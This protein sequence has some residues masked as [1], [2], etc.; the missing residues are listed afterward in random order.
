MNSENKLA[1]PHTDNQTSQ[2]DALNGTNTSL[3]ADSNRGASNDDSVSSK[4][5]D[6]A[7]EN[8]AKALSMCVLTFGGILMLTYFARIEFLPDINLESATTLLYAVSVL[9]LSLVLVLAAYLIMPALVAKA[10]WHDYQQQGDLTERWALGLSGGAA[11]LSLIAS[12]GLVLWK[13]T[14][15]EVSLPSCIA[16]AILVASFWAWRK[17]KC[18]VTGQAQQSDTS[19]STNGDEKKQSKFKWNA[20]YA[21]GMVAITAFAQWLLLL[22]VFLMTYGLGRDGVMQREDA[23]AYLIVSGQL[24]ISALV[25]FAFQKMEWSRAI[26]L[27]AVVGL[28]LVIGLLLITQSVSKPSAIV[29][30]HLG[31]GEIEAT[32][33]V[34]SGK[35]CKQLNLALAGVHCTE[36]KDDEPTVLCPVALRSRIGAQILIEIAPMELQEVKLPKNQGSD[37]KNPKQFQLVWRDYKNSHQ[38]TI[39]RKRVILDKSTLLAWST[40]TSVGVHSDE[41]VPAVPALPASSVYLEA[42]TKAKSASGE[43]EQALLNLCGEKQ[44]VPQTPAPP[45]PKPRPPKPLPQ[46]PKPVAC[47]CSAAP[48]SAAS[49]TCQDATPLIPKVSTETARIES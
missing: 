34:L 26:R 6:Y 46:P 20:G 42:T 12:M 1:A 30:G 10:L 11:F 18:H 32:R 5:R 23:T 14:S 8:P 47:C 2:H 37:D 13:K 48:V 43:L 17:A 21:T 44:P 9:G 27:M 19:E 39:P 7:L 31:A 29:V 33:L 25:P 16:L 45:A 24:C 22:T 49:R 28:A 15:P 40:L 41:N 35:G 4:L 3:S 36:V 38:N